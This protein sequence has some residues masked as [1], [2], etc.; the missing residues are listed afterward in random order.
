[1]GAA[2]WYLWAVEQGVHHL[3]AT[4]DANRLCRTLIGELQCPAVAEL[5]DD[6][7]GR[8]YVCERSNERQFIVTS[9]GRDGRLG[10]IDHEIDVV[11][12]SRDGTCICALGEELPS[13]DF[14]DIENRTSRDGIDS[15]W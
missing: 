8:P 3:Q 5:P 6:P 12:R 2:L 1:M 9:Y 4:A 14:G 7:W 10:G 15:R 11:C 13:S